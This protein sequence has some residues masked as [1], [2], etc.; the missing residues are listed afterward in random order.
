M[1]RWRIGSGWLVFSI[2]SPIVVY[3]AA[4]AAAR[5]ALGSWPN[6]ADLSRFGGLP[7]LGIL[8]VWLLLVLI[9]GFGEEV[10]WR[11]FAL[12]HL[13]K[14]RTLLASALVLAVPW[15]LWH[16][17]LF[18]FIETYRQLGLV[19]LPGFVLGL[20]AGSIVF[21]WLYEQT[22]GSILAVALW[23][24]SFNLVSATVGARGIP[25]AA[26]T[27]AVMICAV[28]IAI[29]EMRATPVPSCA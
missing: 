5:I 12:P 29:R 7:N 6:W 20:V 14:K 17:P 22:G 21:A 19:M 24:G 15:A 23:H 3:L 27:S 11:G 26:V 2:A 4:A 25:A 28:A 9:D 18:F 8:P 1:M 16:V 13:R 10:G